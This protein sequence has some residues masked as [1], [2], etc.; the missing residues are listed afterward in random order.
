MHRCVSYAQ[1]QTPRVSRSSVQPLA[2]VVSPSRLQSLSGPRRTL[3]RECD[4]RRG[5]PAANSFRLCGILQSSAHALGIRETCALA[6]RSPT[7]CC[8]CRHS[9]LGRTASSIRPDMIFGNDTAACALLVSMLSEFG[10]CRK[11]ITSQSLSESV[12]LR[13]C[14]RIMS[15]ND[16]RSAALY[17]KV[18]D[19]SDGP[20][21]SVSA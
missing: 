15:R 12:E 13:G 5:A 19:A 14:Y 9:H 10:C 20:V 2:R 16:F 4:L 8:H 17:E 21:A 6:P 1:A 18:T 11:M 7:V 3:R